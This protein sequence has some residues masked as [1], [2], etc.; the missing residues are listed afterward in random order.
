MEPQSSSQCTSHYTDWAIPIPSRGAN[1]HSSG[2]EIPRLLWNTRVN[3]RVHKTPPVVPILSQMHPAQ[4]F[5]SYLTS[6][7]ILSF[8][9]QDPGELN[10]IA[11]E[12]G[13]DD[14]GFESRQGLGVFLFT[15][16]SRPAPGPTQPPIQWWPVA[17]S[18]GVKRPGR[19]ADHSLPSSA[20]VKNAWSYT[21]VPPLH[22][23]GVVLS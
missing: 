6:I 3:Y 13:L 1:S 4:T 16:L 17:L 21:S 5:P 7:L 2:Q 14:R 15:T 10:G 12:Y 20:E 9:K 11:Q 18:L 19:E 23:H 22:L 8:H